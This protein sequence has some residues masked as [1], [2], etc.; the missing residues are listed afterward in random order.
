MRSL[1]AVLTGAG[2]VVEAAE[3]GVKGAV[4]V[5][6]VAVVQVGKAAAGEAAVEEVEVEEA[7]DGMPGKLKLR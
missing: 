5:A 1:A 7:A 3:V 6:E 2:D 4:R